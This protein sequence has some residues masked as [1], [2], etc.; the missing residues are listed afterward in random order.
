MT[1]PFIPSLLLA[2]GLLVLPAPAA[3]EINKVAARVNDSVVTESEV[4]L[5][6]GPAEGMM[7]AEGYSGEKLKAKL[8]EARERVLQDLI[9]REV[10]LGEFNKMGGQ[11]KEQFVD[12]EIERIIRADYKGDRKRFFA[13]LQRAG[14]TNRKFRELT[15]K[16]LV[17][18]LMRSQVT[19]DTTPPTPEEIKAEYNKLAARIRDEG[20][21][22]KMSK[23]FIP[24]QTAEATPAQQKAL[25]GEIRTKLVQGADFAALARAESKDAMASEGGSWQVMERKFLKREIADAAFA[26]PA[27]GLSP[28]VE[29]ETGF[30]IIKVEAKEGG[31]VP[32]FS[33]LREQAAKM[34]EARKRADRYE[35]YIEE[36][37]KKAVVRRY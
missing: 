13:Y 23:I 15:R 31:K 11:I 26:L 25:A 9:D 22:V 36:L 18:Q 5:L 27:G 6:L 16:R 7:R 4:S 33:E 35:A 24:R 3:T 17:V 14:V 21:A 20:G 19:R 29:D 30:H 12:E 32:P 1:R 28:V 10:I 34:A 8:A 2:A 37:R